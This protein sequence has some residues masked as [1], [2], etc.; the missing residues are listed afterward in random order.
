[1]SFEDSLYN[2]LKSY[3][4]L[5]YPLK[6]FLGK[7]Y[8]LVP[9]KLKYGS[10]YYEY[11]NRINN[12]TNSEDL[13][14]KQLNIACNSLRYYKHIKHQSIS[15]FPII[16]KSIIRERFS[17]FYNNSPKKLLT[18]TGGSSG[19]PFEFYLESGVSRPKEKAHFDWYWGQFGYKDGDRILMIRGESLSNNKLIE[20]Q[21]IGNKLAV[22]CYLLNESNIDNVFEKIYKFLPKHVHAYPSSLKNFL[23]VMENSGKNL[24]PSIRNI[25]LGSEGLLKFDRSFIESR[26]NATIVHWY[27]HSERLVHA[28]NCPYSNE[29]HIYPFYGYVEL[30]DND[31]FL[32]NE[33]FV[34][35]RIIATGFD[36]KVMPLIR[37]DT[38]DEAEYS[39][40][41]SCQCGFTG[42]SFKLIH[43]RKQDY[44]Y[45]NDKTKVSLTAFIY[46]QHFEEF[47]HINEIQL[48]QKRLGELLIRLV[49]N[50]KEAF[51]IN[52]FKDKLEKSVNR[53]IEVTLEVNSSIRKSPSGKHVFLIQK[54]SD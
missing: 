52:R 19:T 43:G 25:F 17:D 4:K 50:K 37:Y 29:F 53:K 20:Y 23:R 14:V 39:E 46:G 2:F 7:C 8:Q 32:I 15:D 24:P 9:K 26:V 22:S 48:E 45:L 49:L 35:G 21:P 38:G 6:W 10:F 12:H 11:I 3:K 36:N 28:G 31:G 34:K 47:A 41:S 1:M 44:I 5:P 40:L 30:V 42:K 18:N 13:L 54:I 16:N 27:G 33:P 51:D